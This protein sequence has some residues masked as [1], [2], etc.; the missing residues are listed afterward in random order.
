MLQ[1]KGSALNVNGLP[2]NNACRTD[3]T[4]S[5]FNIYALK[6]LQIKGIAL[7]VNGLPTNNACRTDITCT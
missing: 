3:I 2:T 1:S 7:K 4:C 6:V 5:R